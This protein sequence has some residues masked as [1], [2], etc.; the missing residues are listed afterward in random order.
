MRDAVARRLQ[1]A[2]VPQA[3]D[4]EY[5]AIERESPAR[6]SAVRRTDPRTILR[7]DHPAV[8]AAPWLGAD[9]VAAV[10]GCATSVVEVAGD[11]LP[12]WLP[13]PGPVGPLVEVGL[14][15]PQFEQDPA[16]WTARAV[17]LPALYHHLAALACVDEA[18]EVSAEAFADDVLTVASAADLHYLVSVPLSGVY[19]DGAELLSVGNVCIRTLSPAEQGTI[20]EQRGGPVSLTDNFTELPYSVLELRVSGPRREQHMRSQER[21]P[22]L[23]AALQ[24]H[25]HHVAVR[26]VAECADPAW[27]YGGMSYHPLVLPQQPRGATALTAQDLQTLAATASQLER[28]HLSEPA[29]AHDLALHR[30]A[31]ALARSSYADAVLDFTIALEALL[32]PYDENTR[33]GD[34]GYRFRIHGAHYLAESVSERRE[35]ARQL[36]RIYEMRSRLVHGAKYP[37]RVQIREAHDIALAL[38]RRGLLRAV[39]DGFPTAP[40]FN[41]MV[42]G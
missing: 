3:I 2:G 26:Y 40:T 33:R 1:D 20:F 24:L 19:L 39:R 34:L 28:Y 25:G 6:W 32:L 36:S 27:V 15:G 5:W 41:E 30:F 22:A 11:A 21:V 13:F 10:M 18:D 9:E 35:I 8:P 7:I 38:A 31:A 37:D 17:L 14:F 29:S 4:V 23:L 42:L 16:G 12:Y